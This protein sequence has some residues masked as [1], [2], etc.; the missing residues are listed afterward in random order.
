MARSIR[1]APC[2][3]IRS[4]STSPS[5]RVGGQTTATVQAACVGTCWSVDGV[6]KLSDG[7]FYLEADAAVTAAP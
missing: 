5:S 3:P 4:S 2:T 1:S 6:A 7:A